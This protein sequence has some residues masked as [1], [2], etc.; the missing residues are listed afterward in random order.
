[1]NSL[2]ILTPVGWQRRPLKRVARINEV[3][4]ADS[5]PQARVIHYIDIGAV[6]EDGLANEPERFRF[7][8]APS[9]ARRVIRAG[10]TIISTVR[11]YLKAVAFFPQPRESLI[12]STGF[13]VLTPGPDVNP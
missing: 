5:T 2:P 9:R 8:D 4:L 7:A 3:E 6:T 10:D 12:A 13:A 11:T 1:M